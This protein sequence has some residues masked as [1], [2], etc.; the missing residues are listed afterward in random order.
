VVHTKRTISA[1]PT[2]I[3]GITYVEGSHVQIE[4]KLQLEKQHAQARMIL[5]V[6]DNLI[7]FVV[8]KDDRA[9]FWDLLRRMYNA[10]DQQQILLLTNK[11]LGISFKDGG[12]ISAYLTEA[13]DLRNHLHTLGETISDK[14]LNN[15]VLNELPSS[16]EMVIQGIAYMQDPSFEDVMDKLLT[17]T[18]RLALRQQNLG[19]KR[20]YLF[21]FDPTDLSI[22]EEGALHHF[23]AVKDNKASFICKDLM[24][25]YFHN[26][27]FEDLHQ[28][29][30]SSLDLSL[31]AQRHHSKG[32]HLFQPMLV[33]FEV[34]LRLQ[35][36][37]NFC[38]NLHSSEA[39]VHL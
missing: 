21:I 28:L 34:L 3:K 30:H 37:I 8:G 1:F 13:N 22:F 36:F 17:E 26:H 6:S 4:E 32:T 25:R 38:I 14:Q 11:L 24:D 23:V 2:I 9:D 10:G 33:L 19:K 18:H 27:H 12:D 20:H 29:Q 5:S 16:Y 15:I 39:L 31:A 35:I 7:G